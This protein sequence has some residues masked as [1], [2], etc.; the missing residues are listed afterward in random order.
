[1]SRVSVQ[2]QGVVKM[3]GTPTYPKESHTLALI[4]EALAAAEDMATC[5]HTDQL[6]AGFAE[7]RLHHL[8][9][10]LN[11][12]AAVAGV[13]VARTSYM[14]AVESFRYDLFSKWTS[15]GMVRSALQDPAAF[16]S[17]YSSLQDDVSRELFD[18]FVHVRVAYA[19]IG[20]QA[21]TL[22]PAPIGREDYAKVILSLGK[23]TPEGYRA[24]K[25]II[26]SEPVAIVDSM[27]REQYSLPGVVEAESGDVVLDIGAYKGETA[28]WFADRVGPEGLVL[29]LEPGLQTGVVLRR[30]IERN[31]SAAMA[32]IGVLQYAAGAH[33]GPARFIATADSSS[34]VSIEGDVTVAMTAVDAMVVEQ[35]LGRVDFMKMD[36]EGG[37][38]DVLRGAEETLKKFTPRLAISVYHKPHNLPDVVALIRETHSDYEFRLSHRSPG[39]GGYR[40][41]RSCLAVEQRPL[42]RGNG[43]GAC[44]PSEPADCGGTM[45]GMSMAQSVAACIISYNPDAVVSRVVEAVRRQVSDVFVIDNDSAQK[46]RAWLAEVRNDQHVIV[47]ENTENR[48][49]AGALNQAAAMALDRGFKWLLLLDQDSIPPSDLVERLMRE[50]TDAVCL[51]QVAVLCPVSI[52]PDAAMPTTMTAAVMRPVDSAMNAGSV[53]RLK[54]W[55]AVSGYDEGL[56]I[57]YVDCDFCF[58]CR[59]SGWTIMEAQDVVMVHAAGSPTR[60]RFL[61]KRPLTSNHSALRR[62]YITRNRIILYRR[63]WH[64]APLWI[65]RRVYHDVKEVAAVVLFESDR[66]LKVTA[67]QAGVVDGLR[68]VTGQALPERSSYL[69][70]KDG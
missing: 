52:G 10:G 38:V 54:A 59:Q 46:N 39:L 36:I 34:T 27:L 37:E 70:G 32:P 30:N 26:D 35:H 33:E 22:Y 3:P 15:V 24:C 40:L 51:E 31:L 57:D 23:R 58:K 50:A 42:D 21:L 65:I 63:Y 7:P 69:E 14:D 11:R 53:V 44:H 17:A 2:Q 67:I 12:L 18:W 8:A 5:R 61:W 6:T 60:H 4:Y 16:D 62:Y 43:M 20:E 9:K 56:F 48:G 19:T 1:M 68:G 45:P 47:L 29:A 25:W 41:V 55:Q 66:R 49:V 13:H 64:F 28:L